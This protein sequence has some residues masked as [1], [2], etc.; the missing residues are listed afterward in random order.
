MQRFL[1]SIGLPYK[2]HQTET[3]NIFYGYCILFKK[4]SNE[5]KLKTQ[6]QYSLFLKKSVKFFI[7]CVG[8]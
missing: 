7:F 2:A 3:L 1:R 6:N 4:Q 5:Q 8:I